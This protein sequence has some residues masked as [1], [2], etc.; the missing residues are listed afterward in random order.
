[1]ADP[2]FVF[3][4]G[5]G[6]FRE[7]SVVEPA[8]TKRGYWVTGIVLMAAGTASAVASYVAM[9]GYYH[10]DWFYFAGLPSFAGIAVGG[11]LFVVGLATRAGPVYAFASGESREP[12]ERPS[13][14]RRSLDSEDPA[15]K[16]E[17]TLLS[18]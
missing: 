8:K 10:S 15:L 9:G 5:H 14:A 3:V 7:G 16:F 17:V 1:M 4:P 2:S 13:L 11:V 18:F 12:Y 6:Y